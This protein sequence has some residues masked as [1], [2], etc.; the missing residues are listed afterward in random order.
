MVTGIVK[1]FNDK[2]GFGF[3][4]GVE[5]EKRDIFLHYSKIDMAGHKTLQDGQSIEFEIEETPKGP[6]AINIRAI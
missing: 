1:F 2:K 5:G 4:E 6:Q 3:A